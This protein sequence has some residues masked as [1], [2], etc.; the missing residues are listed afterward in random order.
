MTSA[1][2][3][4]E[5]IYRH[6]VARPGVGPVWPLLLERGWVHS[7]APGNVALLGDAARVADAL[8]RRFAR[9]ALEDFHAESQRYSHLLPIAALDR[10]HYFSAFPQH[11]T[12][13]FRFRDD[14]DVLAKGVDHAARLPPSERLAPA[15]HVLS[16][17]LCYHSY[18][19]LA[20]RALPASRILT[21]VG[22]CFR[23][24]GARMSTIERSWDFTMREIVFVGARDEVADK[25]ER[26]VAAVR[27]L[28]EALDLDARIETASDPFFA[29]RERAARFFQ[30]ATRAKYELRLGLGQSGDDL[31]ASSFNLHEDF[32][33][34]S[35]GITFG[36]AP[37]TTG[38]VGFGIERWT[39]ALFAQLGVDLAAWP[40]RTRDELSL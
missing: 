30:L 2:P 39:F 10:C 17:A 6:A 14:H 28:V 25:R 38:C 12:F 36:G 9:L 7:T 1:T 20:D 16:P 35:F 8:D 34:R 40:A 21:S 27:T 32:F 22:R 29:E 18:V 11:A 13:A 31:A 19:T 5:V 26:A 3:S 37:A 33:G 23:Y 15:E 24:E 4:P